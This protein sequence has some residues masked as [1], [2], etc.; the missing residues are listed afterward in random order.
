MLSAVFNFSVYRDIRE[1]FPVQSVSSADTG[2]QNENTVLTIVKSAGR[3]IQQ[4]L[5]SF[6]SKFRN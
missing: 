3:R 5:F 6:F 2:H 4:K 1:F